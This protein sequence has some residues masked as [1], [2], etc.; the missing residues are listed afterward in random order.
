MNDKILMEDILTT[1]KAQCDLYLHA[2]IESSTPDVH[3]SF[4][5]CLFELLRIQNE[6]YG[7]MAA[8][9]WYPSQQVP[10]N[11]IQQVEQ[12]FVNDSM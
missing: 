6:I 12:K 2:T 11:K 5:N 9:N 3:Q 4:N 1:V 7:K 8:R 10:I